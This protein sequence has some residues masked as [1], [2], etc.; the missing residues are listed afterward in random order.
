VRA[1]H[2]ETHKAQ[3]MYHLSGFTNKQIIQFEEFLKKN[4]GKRSISCM[5]FMEFAL[6]HGLGI[7]LGSRTDN[8]FHPRFEDFY[9][10]GFTDLEG[11]KV[12]STLHKFD[13][14]SMQSFISKTYT[15]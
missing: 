15:L 11:H 14:E 10:D 1:A 3:M 2:P 6:F 12:A 8:G 9:A 13:K 5:N 4:Q 7:K